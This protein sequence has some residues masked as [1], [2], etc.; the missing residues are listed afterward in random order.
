MCAIPLH[1]STKHVSF[2]FVGHTLIYQIIKHLTKSNFKSRKA[3]KIQF[4]HD[5]VFTQMNYRFL[6]H[7][8]PS[9]KSEKQ[10]KS[11]RFRFKIITSETLKI[12]ALCFKNTLSPQL[13]WKLH[14][15]I[16]HKTAGPFKVLYNEDVA[17]LAWSYPGN[18]LKFNYICPWR[19]VNPL[20]FLFAKTM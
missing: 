16:D 5:V 7:H 20:T 1:N 10:W 14:K 13:V 4:W 17:L 11:I 18:K 2:L 12:M 6:N 19:K 3:I 15:S 8:L 9:K